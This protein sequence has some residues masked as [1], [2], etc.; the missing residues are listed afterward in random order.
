MV[1]VKDSLV[2]SYIDAYDPI[3]LEGW[4]MVLRH[5]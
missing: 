4:V 1:T 3:V 5:F 2:Y